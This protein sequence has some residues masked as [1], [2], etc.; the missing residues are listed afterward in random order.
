MGAGV[1]IGIVVVT[2]DS[3]DVSTGMVLVAAPVV[4]V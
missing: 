4:V 3:V 2:V 1:V